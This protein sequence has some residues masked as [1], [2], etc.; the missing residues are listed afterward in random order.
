M[1][2]AIGVGML[3]EWSTEDSEAATRMRSDL[4][5]IHEV[6]VEHGFEPHVEPT[7]LSGPLRYQSRASLVSFPYSWL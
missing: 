1:G 4:A 3:S 2:L 6:L 7:D 5:A